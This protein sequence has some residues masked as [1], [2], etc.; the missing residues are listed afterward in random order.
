MFYWLDG[1]IQCL[2]PFFHYSVGPNPTSCIA[3]LTFYTDLTKWPDGLTG[4]PGTVSRPTCRVWTVATAS[5]HRAYQA[6]AGSSFGHLYAE[7]W[8][9]T[10]RLVERRGRACN[11]L[12]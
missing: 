7:V 11:R 3:F 1:F 4:R 5:G 2:P 9:G 6:H 10:L 12:I 8:F